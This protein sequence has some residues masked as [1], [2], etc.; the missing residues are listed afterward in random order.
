MKALLFSLLFGIAFGC[1]NATP[2]ERGKIIMKSELAEIVVR[3]VQVKLNSTQE[4]WRLDTRHFSQEHGHLHCL[5][6]R[7][8]QRAAFY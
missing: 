4:P 7:C 3:H 8:G 2:P 1:S 6:S 5:E